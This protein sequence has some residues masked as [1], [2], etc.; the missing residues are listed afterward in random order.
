L[1]NVMARFASKV[2]FIGLSL[3]VF[4]IG[5]GDASAQQV[6][7]P[8]TWG[9]MQGGACIAELASGVA[10]LSY[11][12]GNGGVYATAQTWVQCP[13]NDL[14]GLLSS[15][16]AGVYIE[17]KNTSPSIAT[18]CWLHR[19]DPATGYIIGTT[20]VYS[21]LSETSVQLHS[22][23]P[24]PNASGAATFYSLECYLAPGATLMGYFLN[25]A[26]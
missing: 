20:S 11:Y 23:T 17:M 15:S 18:S 13:V 22:V 2:V 7:G 4:G 6:S 21:G 3:T 25:E 10:N 9:V 8:G 5:S 1:E 14:A 19:V 26:N 24:P 16:S 12:A